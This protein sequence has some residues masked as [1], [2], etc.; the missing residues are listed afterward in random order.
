MTEKRFKKTKENFTCHNC[1]YLTKGSGY[2]NHCPKCLWSKH[3][4]VNPGDRQEICK[5]L[6]KP[7]SVEIKKGDYIIIHECVLC[8]LRK[9]NK[10]AKDDN[11][12][13]LLKLIGV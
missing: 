12:N 7:I 11:F 4:D 13:I 5:G 9:K 3:V 6:M 1:G 8:G 2:T 10:S